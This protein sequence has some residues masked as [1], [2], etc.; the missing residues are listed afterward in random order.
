MTVP[1]PTMTLPAPAV[2]VAARRRCACKGTNSVHS[3]K[4]FLLRHELCD[5]RKQREEECGVVL[6]DRTADIDVCELKDRVEELRPHFVR[7]TSIPQKV[8]FASLQRLRLIVSSPS[9]RSST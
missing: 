1:A 3:S 6:G 7:S 9:S 4:G 5:T 8:G 2:T